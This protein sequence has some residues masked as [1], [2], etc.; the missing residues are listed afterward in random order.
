MRCPYCDEPLDTTI[1]EGGN[2]AAL[3]DSHLRDV[4]VNR[5]GQQDT[6]AP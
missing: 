6:P 4:C 5:P 1:E 2:P 3:Y